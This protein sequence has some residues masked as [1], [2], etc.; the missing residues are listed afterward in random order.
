MN[1]LACPNLPVSWTAVL[2]LS[3]GFIIEYPEEGMKISD[4]LGIS[5]EK[6]KR[7][8]SAKLDNHQYSVGSFVE[9]ATSEGECVVAYILEVRASD[10]NHVSV[11]VAWMYRPKEL[12][13]YTCDG[14]V[15]EGKQAYHGASELIASN[16]VDIIPALSLIQPVQVQQWREDGDD[17]NVEG[18]YWRQ[19][20][21]IHTKELSSAKKYC[22]CQSPE[23]PDE[24][25]LCCTNEE[26]MVWIHYRCIANITKKTAWENEI[27]RLKD[28]KVN[29]D[30]DDK[31]DI[32]TSE[33]GMRPKR[34][35]CRPFS[36]LQ[37]E[38]P[39]RKLFQA[40][41]T[42]EDGTKPSIL[43]SKGG[44]KVSEGPIICPKCDK[45]ID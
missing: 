10:K 17:A 7:Y 14:K 36:Y 25:M 39:W 34:Q 8:K 2:H 40:H 19:G 42:A 11:G 12:G 29:H 1:R 6:M 28:T 16:H 23:N 38:E 22:I 20:V 3:P 21:N 41:I 24:K 27:K 45:S 30:D 37:A 43:I 31:Q 32:T 44:E 13:K 9:V 4:R 15:L 33:T 5:W 18:Y 26:C 35:V